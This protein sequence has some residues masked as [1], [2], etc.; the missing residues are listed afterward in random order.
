MRI[1]S[2]VRYY[3]IP[4]NLAKMKKTFTHMLICSEISVATLREIAKNMKTT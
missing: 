2:T 1:K 4:I 3:F